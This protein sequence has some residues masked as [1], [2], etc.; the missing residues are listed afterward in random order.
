MYSKRSSA[1]KSRA[2]ARYIKSS[3]S[4]SISSCVIPLVAA[5]NFWGFNQ[6]RSATAAVIMETLHW[7]AKVVGCYGES[8]AGEL[9][10]SA[11]AEGSECVQTSAGGISHVNFA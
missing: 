6:T 7:L 8:T 4:C 2:S 10:R 5:Q 9:Y 1:W 3:S 11:Q